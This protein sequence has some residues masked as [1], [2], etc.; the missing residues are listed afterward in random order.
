MTIKNDLL[1]QHKMVGIYL[2]IPMHYSLLEVILRSL[3]PFTCKITLF[4]STPLKEQFSDYP[5]I[6]DVELVSSTERMTGRQIRKMNQQDFI[7]FDEITSF[8]DLMQFAF[9]PLFP[10]RIMIIHDCNTWFSPVVPTTV[11]DF[12]KYVFVRKLKRKFKVFAVAGS[13]M[14]RY[15]KQT[16][17][18]ENVFLIPFS[19]ANFDSEKD[20]AAFYRPGDQIRICIPGTISPRR[21]YDRMIAALS[22]PALRDKMILDFLGEPIGDYGVRMIDRLRALRDQGYKVIFNEGYI[23]NLTFEQSIRKAHLLLSDFETNYTTNNGQKEVYGI[24]KETGVASLML[25]KAKVGLLPAGFHQMEEIR[26]QTLFYR[27]LADV[28]GILHAIY[29]NETSLNH[30]QEN[31]VAN[32]RN[33]DIAHISEEI[34]KAYKKQLNGT[35]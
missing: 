23:D 29:S 26:S 34:L 25:N 6:E 33:M 35:H 22:N 1:L 24:S 20:V 13:N 4:V 31:A 28:S 2:T 16:F 14:K 21:N 10:P 8:R 19:Y 3:A 12:L 18:F 7:L 9:T 5:H 30:L 11:K 17:A 32:A 27:K 15:V